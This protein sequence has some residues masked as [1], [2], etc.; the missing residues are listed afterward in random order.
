MDTMKAVVRYD[1]RPEA[2][3]VR[4]MPVPEIGP[5]EVLVKVAYAG[6]CGTD[7]HTYRSE[8]AGLEEPLIQGH[9]YSGTI[10][11]LGSEVTGWVVGDRVAPESCVYYCGTCKLCQPINITCAGTRGRT[12]MASTAYL[13][14]TR[15]RRP[16]SF[17]GSRRAFH[18]GRPA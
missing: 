15:K 13:Q 3:E 6:I 17:T 2:F 5:D 14:S 10:E 4:D 16:E 9:E 18:C 8:D 1:K 7:P 12:A 11:A